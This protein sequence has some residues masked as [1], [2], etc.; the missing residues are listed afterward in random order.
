[1]ANTP[2]FA[3]PRFDE[4]LEAWKSRL[5]LL[6]LPTDLLWIFD[7]NLC[8]EKNPGEVR[9]GY[10][11]IF[12]P[13][14][15][16]AERIAYEHFSEFNAPLVF[17]RAGS[18]QGKSVCLLLCDKWFEK[19]TEAEGYSKRDDWLMAFRPGPNEQIEEIKDKQRWLNRIVRDRP[20]HDLDFCM[21]LQAIHE[22]LA[23]G[24]V[25]TAYE[26][27]ALKLLHGWRKFLG[28]PQ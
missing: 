18:S 20:I 17:Y 10:Q 23:H 13:P 5:H 19:R 14:P 22:T 11:L 1:M 6:G 9:F 21:T 2:S 27:Y 12:T 8:F 26:R 25:L 4:A 16:D 24:R 3:R 7:E 28:T 15:P